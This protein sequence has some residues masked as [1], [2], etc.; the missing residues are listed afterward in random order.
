MQRFRH[1]YVHTYCV[2]VYAPLCQVQVDLSW[3]GLPSK[4]AP[5]PLRNSFLN[6]DR[7]EAHL[8]RSNLDYH[9]ILKGTTEGFHIVDSLS[10]SP[11]EV[12]NY[13]SVTNGVT[14]PLVEAQILSE[15]TEGC[16]VR[17]RTKP[18]IVSALGAILKP[19]GGIRLIHDG[20]R[21]T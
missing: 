1:W 12:E 5:L 6:P 4:L 9:F 17:V 18:T 7:W 15:I 2:Q 21:L 19:S 16:Y 20:S 14:R 8:P 11:A 13:T 10:C 3:V